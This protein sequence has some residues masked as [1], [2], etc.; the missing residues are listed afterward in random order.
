[1]NKAELLT[2]FTR[3]QRIEV[4]FPDMR[5]E[6]QGNVIRQVSLTN[7]SGF[8][9]YSNL[10]ENNVEQAIGEQIAFFER[11][12]QSFEWKVYDYDRPADLKERLRKRGLEVGEPE[13]LMV[14]DLDSHPDLLEAA[15]P[16]GIR[17]IQGPAEINL[18]DEIVALE[19]QVWGSD[20]RELGERLKRD[21][22][23]DPRQLSVWAAYQD[24][25]IVSAAWTYFQASGSLASLWGGSTLSEYRQRGFYSGLLA[26]RSQEALRRGFR[27]LTVDASEMSRTILQKFGFELLSFSTPCVWEQNSS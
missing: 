22:Q 9:V 5:R 21:L 11:L 13:A 24:G 27:F 1:M 25:K 7:E 14:L 3:D 10:G 8:I 26:A 2:L 18:I 12:G 19:E 16:E 15:V 4:A 17:R 6:V 20:H 23:T